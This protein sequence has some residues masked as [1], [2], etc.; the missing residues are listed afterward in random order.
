VVNDDFSHYARKYFSF[1][2]RMLDK[3]Q[4]R[5]VLAPVWGEA[6]GV[7]PFEIFTNVFKDQKSGLKRP[8]D[9]VNHSLYFEAKTFLNGL[10]V[11]EDKLSMSSDISGH[12]G[13]ILASRRTR[14]TP[15]SGRRSIWP[16]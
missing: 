14:S 2:Q 4:L 9:Y 15:I 16:G 11:V 7:D 12:P 6:K 5:S 8:E 3:E 1:W 10:L 13:S